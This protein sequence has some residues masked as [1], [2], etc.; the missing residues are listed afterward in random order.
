M[1]G[2]LHKGHED[3]VA[4]EGSNSLSE[5]EEK[6]GSSHTSSNALQDHW[7]KVQGNLSHS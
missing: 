7:K 6:V 5:C 4:V 1:E 2:I 3:H